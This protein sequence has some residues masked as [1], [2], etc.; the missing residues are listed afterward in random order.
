[1]NPFTPEEKEDQFSVLT[2]AR[3]QSADD[4]L[5]D[6]FQGL[7]RLDLSGWDVRAGMTWRF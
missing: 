4:E 6:D 3:W 1:M 2:E 5:S 7:G